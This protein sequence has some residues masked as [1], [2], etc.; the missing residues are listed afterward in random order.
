MSSSE[1]PSPE[2]ILKKEA[3]P[4][5]L[6]EKNSGNALEAS[7]ALNYTTTIIG[8][9]GSQP[10]SL[11][12]ISGNALRAFPGSFRNFS[13]TSSGK[14]EPYWGYGPSWEVTRKFL[15]KFGV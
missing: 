7:K 1:R 6:G 10:Y 2:P 11:R 9:G 8:L 14:S 4:A 13:G 12:G 5:V 3:S 15:E